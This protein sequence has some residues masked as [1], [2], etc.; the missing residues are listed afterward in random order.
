MFGVSDEAIFLQYRGVSIF[1][2]YPYDDAGNCPRTNIYGNSTNCSDNEDTY[3][4]DVEELP[5]PDGVSPMDHVAIIRAAIDAGIPEVIGE[6]TVLPRH[7]EQPYVQLRKY[8]VIGYYDKF[9]EQEADNFV[10][11]VQAATPDGAKVVVGNR[12]NHDVKCVCV[13]DAEDLAA[14]LAKVRKP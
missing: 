8:A 5:V 7:E 4:F 13:L 1:H 2:V 12:R 10:D 14:I 6:Q 3:T 9:S 11:V